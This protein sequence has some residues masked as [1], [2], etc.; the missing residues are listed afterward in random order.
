MIRSLTCL[1]LA[2]TLGAACA[3]CGGSSS[4]GGAPL[5]TSQPS[6]PAQPGAQPGAPAPSQPSQ[7]SQPSSPSSP[8]SPAPVASD[9]L[10]ALSAEFTSA[11]DLSAFSRIYQVEGWGFDQL[12]QADVGTT[13]AGWLTLVPHT[14]SWYEDYRGILVFKQVSGDFVATAHIVASDRAGTNAP[15]RSYSL[16]G[17]MIRAPRAI[18]PA[19]WTRGGEDY[20]FLSL[21]AASAPGTF[22]TEVKTTDES[23]SNLEID[24][25]PSG[26]EATIRVA[27]IGAAVICLIRP[28]G[29]EWRVHRRYARADLPSGLQVGLTVYTDW[30]TIQA[31]GLTPEQHNTAQIA[32]GMPDL[33][34]QV[35]YLRY[36]R[37]VVPAALTGRTLSDPN[38]VSDA[39]L[40]SFLGG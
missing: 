15:A 5:P 11:A 19:T 24:A 30:Q 36:A 2:L 3:G 32:G 38:Q 9:D 22:Q 28:A 39:E 29:G 21:G 26:G 23:V 27:R 16:A 25:A 10:S 13:R 37:P 40:L 1:S 6:Q 33:R 17:I 31:Q 7:P 4:G 14:S 35:D 20:V 8:S 12:E 18:T 34:A